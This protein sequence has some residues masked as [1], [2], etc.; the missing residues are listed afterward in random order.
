MRNF[1]AARDP[2]FEAIRQQKIIAAQL[3]QQSTAR[4]A[5]ESDASVRR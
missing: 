5:S 3:L 1:V 4:L 2:A